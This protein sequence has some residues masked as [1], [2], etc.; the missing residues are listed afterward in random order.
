M[1]QFRRRDYGLDQ[2]AHRHRWSRRMGGQGQSAACSFV[3][4]R[5][6]ETIEWLNLFLEMGHKGIDDE[7]YERRIS[8]TPYIVVYEIRRKPERSSHN[9]VH[10]ARDRYTT[11]LADT[12][13]LQ[14][15]RRARALCS[16]TQRG[17]PILRISCSASGDDGVV[18][19][20]FEEG[21]GHEDD[22]IGSDC[23][24]DSRRHRSSSERSRSQV[25]LRPARSQLG[26]QLPVRHVWLFLHLSGK[27]GQEQPRFLLL[28]MLLVSQACAATH[29][30]PD[31]EPSR[32]PFPFTSAAACLR[33]RAD[34]MSVRN[35]FLR[36][37]PVI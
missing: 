5:I 31:V 10:G 18:R 36:A 2:A 25:V 20:A 30:A 27:R 33:F 17:R 1:R 13:T 19:S 35:C 34:R 32:G 26:W 23:P 24:V 8:D 29:H 12:E 3:V 11:Q 22:S 15:P 21:Y 14:G 16:A 4:E 37:E 9:R 28:P 6:L 7:T